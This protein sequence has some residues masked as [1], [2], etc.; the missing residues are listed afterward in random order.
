MLS[1]KTRSGG[2]VRSA[3][4][5]VRR[6]VSAASGNRRSGGVRSVASQAEAQ[7]AE[8]AGP[9]LI[10]LAAGVMGQGLWLGLS[11]LESVMRWGFYS[12]LVFCV[13]GVGVSAWHTT[14]S[15][16]T[17]ALGHT[18]TTIVIGGFF[19]V[20]TAL[21]GLI[22]MHKMAWWPW[23]L[24]VPQH[25]TIELFFLAGPALAVAW[26]IRQ[27]VQR[28]DARV[29]AAKEEEPDVW[30]HAGLKGVKGEFKTVNEYKMQA[31]LAIPSWLTFKAVQH[32]AKDIES[33]H[34]FPLHS[35]RILEHP[36]KKSNKALAIA[37]T[38]DPHAEAVKWPG[39]RIT[40]GMSL[41]SPI[42]TGLDQDGDEAYIYV[43]DPAGT[44]HFLV[45]GMTGSGKSESQKPILLYTSRL[46]AVNIIIDTV[47]QTQTFGSMAPAIHW[48]V[49][50][51]PLA[52]SVIRRIATHVIPA[53]TNQLA[54]EGLS[55]W[56]PKSSMALLRIHIEEAW[57]LV[58]SD[59]IAD[60]ARAARSAGIQ[61]VISLQ[62]PSHDQLSTTVR[63][64]LG[65]RQIFGLGGH[66]GTI[67]MDEEVLDAGAD[68]EKWKDEQP[69]MHYMQRKG[70]SANQKATP[71]RS[72]YDGDCEVT[73][74][75]AAHEIGPHL[76]EMDEVT[77]TAFGDLWR[78]RVRPVELVARVRSAGTVTPSTG[79]ALRA[80]ADST[81]VSRHPSMH[82]P[83]AA[84]IVDAGPDD[85]SDDGVDEKD[86]L[87][88]LF[89]GHGQ[90]FVMT[91]GGLPEEEF[92]LGA[93]DPDPAMSEAIRAAGD[94]YEVPGQPPDREPIRLGMAPKEAIPREELVDRMQDKLD[95]LK[96]SGREIVVISDFFADVVYPSG[97]SRSMGYKI[98]GWFETGYSSGSEDADGALVVLGGQVLKVNEGW[99]IVRN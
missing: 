63:E 43:A 42:P 33:A 16:S 90:K 70:L 92:D 60:I 89:R 9:W 98:M 58:E 80:A 64:Q 30:E 1:P 20:V 97:W 99:Q 27:G 46:G 94:E 18:M 62:R 7:N 47:K 52:R 57:A 87:M 88:S 67:V 8:L 29:A 95:K 85:G 73:F 78:N 55:A 34:G 71:I 86:P 53:R 74:E 51:A 37:M 13:A 6:G 44:K 59:E 82:P 19:L 79:E 69:G 68:P 24:P 10:W 61:L 4:G 35:V 49:I 72:Y 39:M 76:R 83:V 31:V 25:G 84:E 12:L 32:H 26:N 14:K 56:S 5:T 66:F 45:T 38:K 81:P 54:R 17:L 15:R 22:H 91:G 41:F 77:A 40:R 21:F 28:G 11:P 36:S 50:E 48:L 65:T 75:A 3:A 2:R 96:E 93:P 23:P